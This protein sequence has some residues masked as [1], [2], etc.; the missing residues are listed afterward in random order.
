MILGYLIVCNICLYI[1]IQILNTKDC[2][3]THL[4]YY[5]L[6]WCCMVISLCL[7]ELPNNKTVVNKNLFHI[8]ERVYGIYFVKIIS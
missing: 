6:P 8:T 2:E 7:K 5:L 3:I 4:F 1:K